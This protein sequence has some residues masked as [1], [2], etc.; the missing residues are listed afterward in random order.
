MADIIKNADTIDSVDFG[1]LRCI[2]GDPIYKSFFDAFYSFF[3]VV[4]DDSYTIE[5]KKNFVR[6]QFISL[7]E[8]LK[9]K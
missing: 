2:L 7:I 5:V 1:E 6:H 4:D 9:R 8:S 3:S